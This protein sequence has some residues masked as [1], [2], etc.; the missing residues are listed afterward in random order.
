[1]LGA[2]VKPGITYGTTDEI[3]WSITENPVHISDLHA[4]LLKLF[5]FDH[6]KLGYEHLGVQQ[7]LTPLTRESKVIDALLA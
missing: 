4:T 7:R 3:G 1:M 2:G 5:G 6:M